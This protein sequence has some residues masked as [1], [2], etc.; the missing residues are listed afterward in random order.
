MAFPVVKN[1][2][3]GV[4][5]VDA[6]YHT[7]T[8]SSFGQTTGDLIVLFVSVIGTPDYYNDGPSGCGI[9]P[10]PALSSIGWG[11]SKAEHLISNHI[12]IMCK[13]SDGNANDQLVIQTRF[14]WTNSNNIDFWG[15]FFACKISYVAFIITGYSPDNIS[16]FQYRKTTGSIGNWIT[17]ACPTNVS[18]ADDYIWLLAASA[19]YD[20]IATV[21]PTSFSSLIIAQGTATSTS[22][23]VS[24][25]YRTY[26]INQHPQTNFTAP[27][28]NYE[29]LFVRISP[30]SGTPDGYQGFGIYVPQG[31]IG[32]P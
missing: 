22:T 14:Y 27:L 25:C 18:V 4:E 20:N 24:A 9:A 2:V 17:N 32:L 5:T 23:S 29:T 21:A 28:A 13:V 26:N 15:S 8:T 12:L 7:I 31:S 11:I 3:T 1:T 10:V 6:I 19:N 16:E 30:G